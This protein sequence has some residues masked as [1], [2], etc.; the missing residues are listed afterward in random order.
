MKVMTGLERM[1]YMCKCQTPESPT[2][3]FSRN[4]AIKLI[5]G[6]VLVESCRVMEGIVLFEL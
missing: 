2:L 3:R 1:V 5:R 4:K 6:E